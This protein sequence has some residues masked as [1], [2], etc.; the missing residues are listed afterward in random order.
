[1]VNRSIPWPAPTIINAWLIN[2]QIFNFFVVFTAY[3]IIMR[4]ANIENKA[5]FF[6]TTLVSASPVLLRTV[7][8]S[9]NL[10]YYIRRALLSGLV[11]EKLEAPTR[12]GQWQIRLFSACYCRMC[13][14]NWAPYFQELYLYFSFI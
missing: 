12:A 7:N 4:K 5:I 11:H 6:E 3:L 1:M 10:I 8:V 13:F 9:S 14:Y 2:V